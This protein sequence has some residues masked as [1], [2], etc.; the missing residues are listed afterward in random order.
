MTCSKMLGILLAA[1]QSAVYSKETFSRVGWVGCGVEA[2]KFGLCYR[3]RVGLGQG[4]DF[5]L[6]GRCLVLGFGARTFE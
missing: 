2:V 3:M 4:W 6:V 1:K 5:C